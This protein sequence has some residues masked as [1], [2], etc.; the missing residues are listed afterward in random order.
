MHVRRVTQRAVLLTV[1]FLG[2]LALPGRAQVVP[3]A[4]IEPVA[5]SGDPAPG[6][7][8]AILAWVG[9]TR[10]DAAGNVMFFAFLDGPGIDDSNYMAIF[11]GTPG[12]MQPLVWMSQPAPNMPEGFIISSMLSGG[13]MLSEG[14]WI[15]LTTDQAGPGIVEDVNDRAVFVGPPGDL[16]MVLQG[17]DQAPGCEPGV[18]IDVE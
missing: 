13:A 14:G 3:E 7:P 15:A 11:Y 1:L 8:D 6:I 18:Y 10:I 17:G 2:A 5:Q 4:I 9:G 12:D 16:R